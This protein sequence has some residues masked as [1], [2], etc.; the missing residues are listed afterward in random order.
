MERKSKLRLD[1]FLCF[2]RTKYAYVKVSVVHNNRPPVSTNSFCPKIK[3]RDFNKDS[4]T[5]V[6]EHVK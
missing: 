3:R 2:K 4:I 5:F 1:N 6:T